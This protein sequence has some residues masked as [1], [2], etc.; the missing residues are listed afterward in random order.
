MSYGAYAYGAGPFGA[1]LSGF[2]TLLKAE[3]VTAASFLLSLG[4]DPV[5]GQGYKSGSVLGRKNWRITVLDPGGQSVLVQTVT[6]VSDSQIEIFTDVS[7]TDVT[8]YR[9]EWLRN[10]SLTGRERVTVRTGFTLAQSYDQEQFGQ[11]V[12]LTDILTPATARDTISRGVN[13]VQMVGG[14]FALVNDQRSLR[15]RI[16]RRVSAAVGDFSHL[17]GYGI[18]QGLGR[19]ITNPVITDLESQVDGQVRLEPEVVDIADLRVFRRTNNPAAVYIVL[20][21]LTPGGDVPIQG[22]F[23]LG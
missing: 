13:T 1:S 7:V 19:A 18:S 11:G 2:V 20:R 4:G 23:V 22:E 9:I 8:R 3:Q 6:R 14:D 12:F 16:Y 17:A 21:A 5:F 10:P 15:Q